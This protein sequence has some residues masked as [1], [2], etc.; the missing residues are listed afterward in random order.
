MSRDEISFDLYSR[1]QYIP[2]SYEE[3]WVHKDNDSLKIAGVVYLSPDAPV[4]AGTSIYEQIE[5]HN[6]NSF[7]FRNK[8]YSQQDVNLDEYRIERDKHNSHFK[9][10]LEVGN[11]YNRLFLYNA[12]TWHRESMFFGDD[13][14]SSRLTLVF[15]SDVL[16]HGTTKTPLIRSKQESTY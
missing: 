7:N 9:K 8:F 13:K 15:F 5:P 4:E 14:E 10:T 12:Q 3:G 2:S 1:F 11:V 6:E 16:T